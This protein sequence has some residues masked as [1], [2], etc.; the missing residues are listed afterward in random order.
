MPLP[1]SEPRARWKRAAR[2]L[3]VAAVAPLAAGCGNDDASPYFGATTRPPKDVATFYSNTSGEPEYLDPGKANDTA[4]TALTGQLF[5][6]LTSPHPRDTHPVQ[7][8]AQSF[9]RSADN[10]FYR[11][12]L[13]PDAKWSDGVQVKA[14][15]FEYAWKRVLRPAT[16]SRAA[17]ALQ[18]IANG[19]LFNFGKLKVVTRDLPLLREPRDD[20][21]AGERLARGAA[22]EVLSQSPRRVA[23]AIAPLAA[24]PTGVRFVSWSKVD[25]KKG[26]PEQLSFGGA[27]PPVAAAANDAW[28][29]AEV[30]V[31][32]AGPEVDCDAVA[33]RWFLVQRGAERG[34]LPGCMLG[35]SKAATKT[36]ALVQRHDKLP[37]YRP[38]AAPPPEGAT[39]PAPVRG[40]VASSDLAEDDHVLGVR[41]TDDLTLEVELEQ[42]TPYFLELTG[43]S[44][45]MPVRRD[46]IEAFEKRGDPDLWTRPENI[47]TNGPYTLGP[48]KFRYELTMVASPYYWNRDKL[49]IHRIVWLEIEDYHPT[50]NLYK[51]GEIDYIGDS[52]ALPSEYQPILKTK[53]DYR[54][55]AYLSVYWYE[56][57][58]K[59]PPLDDVRVR[60]ALNLAIDKKQLVEKVARGGQPIATHFVPDFT[61]LGYS[62]QVA[63]DKAAGTDPF[64][65]PGMDYN[66]ELARSLMKEAGY[67]VVQDG[68]GQRA[69]R[70]PPVEIL[71]NTSEGHKN[72]A[73]AIQDMWKRNLGVTATLRN[74]EW[75]VM[76]KNHRDGN[77]NVVRGGWVG[78]VNHP[79]T[80]LNV[81]TSNSPENQ[82]GWADPAFDAALKTAASISDPAESMRAYRKA[83]LLALAGMARIPFYFYTKSTLIK[84]WVKGFWG[85]PRGTHLI[86]YLWIDPDGVKH[87]G[88]ELAYQPLELPPPGAYSP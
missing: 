14:S 79:Q 39:P 81:F 59:K 23:A 3:V 41:A 56:L 78:E 49:R 18:V 52:A 19:E 80:F 65:G 55:N 24:A 11:F 46:V 45:A 72:V 51:A 26:T 60:R 57:N 75:K 88:N 2:A 50:M 66:P 7:G 43:Q 1:G 29:D 67:P 44:V 31:L 62:D 64:T 6:G 17:T 76:L 8:V 53:K 27:R 16:A 58:T 25:A 5:E 73:V 30:L 9:E 10:R 86:Q 22:V 54:N 15:D 28:K 63:V 82:T 35:P 85:L 38:P 87:E 33:D 21:G 70:C 42:P 34:Y 37:T 83:E 13:R 77:F 84:P 61:G 68:N 12:H 4:S 32:E 47:V 69:D 20:A 36:Y 74:E 40:F 71:Y 48:A